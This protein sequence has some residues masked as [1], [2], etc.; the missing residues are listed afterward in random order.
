MTSDV[1]QFMSENAG[2]LYLNYWLK[3]IMGIDVFKTS[4]QQRGWNKLLESETRTQSKSV[5]TTAGQS[6]LNPLQFENPRK[7]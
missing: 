3:G 1:D 4:S 7:V 5:E 6:V 2:G